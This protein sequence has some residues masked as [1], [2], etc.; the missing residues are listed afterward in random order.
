EKNRQAIAERRD[1]FRRFLQQVRNRQIEQEHAPSGNV[2]P[3]PYR[4][5]VLIVSGG[6]DKGAF[7]AGFL[8]GWKQVPTSHEMALP[9]FDVVTG[10]STGALIAPFAFLGG[11]WIDRIDE[12]YRHPKKDWIKRRRP[13]YFLPLRI[14]FAAVPGLE[15]DLRETVTLEMARRIHAAGESG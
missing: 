5:D 4:F 11:E 6:G 3:R 2:G 15:R 10:V 9:E 13:F 12:L 14:S 8:K 1:D 7:G